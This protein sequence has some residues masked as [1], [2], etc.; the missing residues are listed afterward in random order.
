M[1]DCPECGAPFEEDED[2]LAEGETLLCGECGRSFTVASL[3]PLELEP[4]DDD[5][6]LD[7]DFD[8]EEDEFDEEDEEDE[9]EE[10]EEDW[11]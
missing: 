10:D 6:D 1:I 8:E 5:F 4:E 11:R 3:D 2:E 7:E 9:E